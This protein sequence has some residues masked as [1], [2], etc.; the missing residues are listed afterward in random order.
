MQKKYMKLS[1]PWYRI[2]PCKKN[3]WNFVYFG[4]GYLSSTDGAIFYVEKKEIFETFY[5]CI[6]IF[7][8]ES[9]GYFEKEKKGKLAVGQDKQRQNL[10]FHTQLYIMY[11]YHG[12]NRN[13]SIWFTVIS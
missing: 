10:Y 11:C 5:V 2:W 1:L 12:V 13:F 6:N 4:T 9:V 8:Y 7:R 3:T